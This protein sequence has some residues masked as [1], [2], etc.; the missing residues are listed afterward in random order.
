MHTNKHRQTKTTKNTQKETTKHITKQQTANKTSQ[1]SRAA[2]DLSID[3]SRK[4]T[5]I[6]NKWKQ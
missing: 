3:K 1:T 2:K 5:I 6:I 4:H